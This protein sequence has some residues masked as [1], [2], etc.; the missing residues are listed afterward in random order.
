MAN[1]ITA[2]GETKSALGWEKDERSAVG[3]QQILKRIAAGMSAEDAISRPSSGSGKRLSGAAQILAWGE[4]KSLSGWAQDDRCA[5]SRNTLKRRLSAGML[6]ELAISSPAANKPEFG[7][8]YEAWGER[9]LLADWLRDDRCV[10]SNRST[11]QARLDSGWALETALS[12]PVIEMNHGVLFEAFGDRL[13]ATEWCADSRSAVSST[14]TFLSRVA[15]GWPVEEALSVPVSAGFSRGE[16]EFADF[17]CSLTAVDRNVRYVLGGQ[18]IDVWCPAERVGFEY[19]GLFWHSE[20]FKPRSYHFDKWQAASSA[21]V[22]LFQVWEDDWIYRR[23]IVENFVRSKL[24]LLDGSVYARDC[25]VVSPSL[26]E[27][28]SL[29]EAHHLQGG[30]L[31]ASECV[32]L[33]FEGKL[34]CVAVFV[35]SGGEFLLSRFAGSGRVV[36]GFQRCLSRFKRRPVVSFADLCVSDGGSYFKAGFVLDK[37]LPPDYSYVFSGDN[38]RLHKFN[39]RKDRFRSDPD[40]VWRDGLTELELA[41]LNGL[42]RVFDAGKLRLVLC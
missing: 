2:W 35:E 21:G 34:V 14:G 16:S 11:L 13:T 30:V 12:K 41:G 4:T 1:R 24:G 6:P 32:G 27:A 31:T 40:L 15:A 20:N 28:N 9:K 39:F 3:R 42:Y 25:E 22:K 19:N 18:E 7:V 5:V 33:V 26:A 10:V 17:V 38:R 23:P 8:L 37:V 29:L 36:G